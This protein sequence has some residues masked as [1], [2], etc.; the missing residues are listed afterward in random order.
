MLGLDPSIQ[1]S[2]AVPVALDCRL[3]AGNDKKGRGSRPKPS[4]CGS[5]GRRRRSLAADSIIISSPMFS[6]VM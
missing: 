1:G 5:S 3:K 6:D 2:I 4:Y